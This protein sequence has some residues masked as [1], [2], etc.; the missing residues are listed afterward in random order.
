MLALLPR[1]WCWKEMEWREGK[2]TDRVE[3]VTAEFSINS[4]VFRKL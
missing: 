3:L 4:G 1:P 2:A